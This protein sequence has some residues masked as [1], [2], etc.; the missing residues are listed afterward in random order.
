MRPLRLR[1]QDGADDVDGR[2]HAEGVVV[3]LVDH[4]PVEARLRGVLQLVEVHG[5]ELLR[6]LGAELLVG[7]H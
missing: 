6:A 3:V 5:V 1:G 2:H 7:K 4:D